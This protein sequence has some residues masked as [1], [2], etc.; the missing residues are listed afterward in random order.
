MKFND[1][2]KSAREHRFLTQEEAANVLGVS[3]TS[4]QKWE[5]DTLPDK[6]MWAQ[7][8]KVYKLDQNEFL[9]NYGESAIPKEEIEEENG[10]SQ[11]PE[12][13]IPNEKLAQIKELVL[14]KDEQELLGLEALYQTN[15]Y[16]VTASFGIFSLIPHEN[17]IGLPYEYVK[18][19]GSFKVMALHDSLTRKLS[20]Y[21]EY[22]ISQIKAEPETTFNINNC[23][24]EQLLELF[25][26]VSYGSGRQQKNLYEVLAYDL[27]ELRY[28]DECAA[29]V[30]ISRYNPKA[31]NV[32]GVGVGD[33][34]E[35]EKNY[36]RITKVSESFIE[37][38]E[39]END[40][41]EYMAAKEQYEKDMEFYKE[42]QN[43]MDHEPAR[44][45]YQAYKEAV[46][47]EAGRKFLEWARDL[48]L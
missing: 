32:L 42:H 47:T 24:K 34:W 28:I 21:R 5:K 6:S 33:K 35:N 45:L 31:R 41:P 37:I 44:P 8:I 43:M 39:K 7:I 12:F 15:A 1:Y 18:S 29:P 36:S 38:V 10:D 20:E 27:E 26:C 11:F 17:S 2:M 40:D 16:K 13:L 3:T 14:T 23:S 22:V 19:K 9:M 30:I 46:I 48:D 4:V 25:R